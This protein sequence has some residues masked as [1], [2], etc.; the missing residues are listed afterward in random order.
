[1]KYCVIILLKF[2]LNELNFDE[3]INNNLNKIFN[4]NFNESYLKYSCGIYLLQNDFVTKYT[5]IFSSRFWNIPLKL[6]QTNNNIL[7]LQLY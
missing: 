4:D 5:E 2:K 3:M 1:M 6:W 7:I